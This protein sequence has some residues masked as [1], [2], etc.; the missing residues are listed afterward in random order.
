MSDGMADRF[1]KWFT[2]EQDAHAKVV[3]SL[4]SVP[5]DRRESPE[6]KKAVG[7]LAHLMMARTVWLFR[8]GAG[9]APGGSIFPENMPL[10]DV[11]TGLQAVQGGWSTYLATLS[12]A[13]LAQTIDYKSFDGGKWHSTVEEILTHL[14]GHSFYHRGQIATLVRASG[15]EPAK[16]DFIV[17]CRERPPGE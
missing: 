14:F 9:P 15:G 17:W 2:Y 1:R 11:V 6:Y 12:D 16:T 4:E 8:L 10:A 13:A 5:P 7:W 3:A